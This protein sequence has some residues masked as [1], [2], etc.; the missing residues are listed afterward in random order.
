MQVSPRGHLSGITP[1]PLD[2]PLRAPM[3]QRAAAGEAE[4]LTTTAQGE[5]KPDG[6]QGDREAA[7]LGDYRGHEDGHQGAT[8]RTLAVTE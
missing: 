5:S 1:S 3:S 2:E 8:E 4:V 6:P 7:G